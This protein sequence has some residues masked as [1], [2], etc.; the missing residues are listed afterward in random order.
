MDV[1]Y[2]IQIF[3]APSCE[4]ENQRI[5]KKKK[6]TNKMRSRR[7]FYSLTVQILLR[8]MLQLTAHLLYFF[9]YLPE[10]GRKRLNLVGCLL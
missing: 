10:D 6:D 1:Y 2:P 5:N 4:V 9:Q 8:I 3:K 7:I